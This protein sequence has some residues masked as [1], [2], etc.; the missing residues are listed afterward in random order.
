MS[1]ISVFIGFFRL[2]CDQYCDQY[3][4]R[5]LY[6]LEIPN[7]TMTS[8]VNYLAAKDCEASGPD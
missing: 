7:Y 1:V 8:D 2:F 4:D 5:H 3:C 6:L